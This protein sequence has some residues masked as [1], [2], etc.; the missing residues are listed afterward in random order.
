MKSKRWLGICLKSK[1]STTELRANEKPANE[2][3][4]KSIQMGCKAH[5]NLSR[6]VYCNSRY[7]CNHV[8][9]R[10]ITRRINNIPKLVNNIVTVYK[11]HDIIVIYSKIYL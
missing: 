4:S 5:I 2:K 9:G 8:I 1:K 7:W 6:L 11:S 3:I 10:I